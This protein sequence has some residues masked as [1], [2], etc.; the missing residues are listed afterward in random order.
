MWLVR[1][2]L[3]NPKSTT[4]LFVVWPYLFVVMEV[5]EIYEL[6][7]ANPQVWLFHIGISTNKRIP[8]SWNS[9]QVAKINGQALEDPRGPLPHAESKWV[10]CTPN[11]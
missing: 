9:L 11:F 5:E 8:E 1:A 7:S 6:L 3:V 10:Q 2:E 4:D